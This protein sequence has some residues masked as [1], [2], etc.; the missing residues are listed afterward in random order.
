M[1]QC[2]QCMCVRTM[3]SHLSCIQHSHISRVKRSQVIALVISL[4]VNAHLIVALCAIFWHFKAVFDR[5]SSEVQFALFISSCLVF[6]GMTRLSTRHSDM[7]QNYKTEPF[8]DKFII[9]GRNR[10]KRSV[11]SG[12]GTSLIQLG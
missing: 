12:G 3:Y 4:C 11:Y 8:R 1:K 5:G 6:T 10:E 7:W 9:R 2:V